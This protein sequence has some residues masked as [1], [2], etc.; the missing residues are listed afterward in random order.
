MEEDGGLLL[1]VLLVGGFIIYFLPSMVGYK[2]KKADAII[3]L[4]LLLGWTFIGW[5]V[6]LVWAVAAEPKPKRI[7]KDDVSLH[8]WID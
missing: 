8:E 6:A 2:K 7:Q 3:I 1:A 4:N 5:V